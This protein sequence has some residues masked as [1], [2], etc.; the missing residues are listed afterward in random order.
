MSAGH[1]VPSSGVPGRAKIMDTPTGPAVGSNRRDETADANDIVRAAKFTI[2]NPPCP[3][4]G[5]GKRT[6]ASAGRVGKR[7]QSTTLP[8][9]LHN[10]LFFGPHK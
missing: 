1:H 10:L 7:A 9:A 3:A 5:P 2:H 8:P 6:H 4:A